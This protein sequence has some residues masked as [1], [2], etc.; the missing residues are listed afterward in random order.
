MIQITNQLEHS[1]GS[2]KKMVLMTNTKLRKWLA[3][4]KETIKKSK[5]LLKLS[6]AMKRFMTETIHIKFKMLPTN[7]SIF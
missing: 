4:R 3:R 2:P 5:K 7:Q 1:L 6:F